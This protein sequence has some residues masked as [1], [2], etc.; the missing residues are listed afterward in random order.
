[1]LVMNAM[2]LLVSMLV[3]FLTVL[4]TACTICCVPS[5]SS[6]PIFSSPPSMALRTAGWLRMAF[7][8]SSVTARF[9]PFSRYVGRL[10]AKSCT[11]L[12]TMGTR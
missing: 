1:M 9:S 6:T 2:K 7:S 12:T 3:T 11:L 8:S 10:A 5:S 4:G